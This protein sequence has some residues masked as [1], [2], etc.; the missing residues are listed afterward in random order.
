[1]A[2]VRAWGDEVPLDVDA[3]LR[4]RLPDMGRKLA[5]SA[6]RVGDRP[7]VDVLALSGGGSDGAFGAGF[8]TGWTARG[9]RPHFEI[10]TGVSAGA[11]I[12]PFAFLGPKYDRQLREIWTEYKTNELVVAQVLPGLLGGPALADTS[13][14]KRLIADYVDR[15]MLAEIAAE[16]RRG[17]ILLIGTTNLDAERPVVWN[18][19]RI[20]ASTHPQ[21]LDLFRRV[22]LAS[23]A[24][25]GVFPP[26]DITVEADGKTYE[27][28]HVDGGTT[29][30]L[31]V[32]P[33]Q[34]PYK[35]FDRYYDTPPLRR[36]FIIKN[37][38]FDPE[39]QPVEARTIPIAARAIRTLIKSQNRSEMYRIYRMTKDDG[40]DFNLV[41]I[42][43][44]FSAQAKEVFD[45]KYQTALFQEGYK[46]GASGTAWM[47]AP[48]DIVP[49]R[50]P[51]PPRTKRQPVGQN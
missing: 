15:R 2:G 47:K 42:P 44:A 49:K 36:F 20:A 1:M 26:V 51:A 29:R 45:P 18:M 11:I 23:A 46:L 16:Y 30:E 37:G 24:I 17:R 50:K 21:A 5:I 28:M 14:L 4:R 12:A 27:E 19:G 7:V 13:P 10:V 48:P 6:V 3:E 25:P 31:F 35:N 43:D 41:A 40:A 32:A 33:M 34:I 8:L 9:D 22:I 38:K 39:Y